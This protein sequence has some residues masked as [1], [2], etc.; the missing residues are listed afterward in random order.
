MRAPRPFLF[1]L[2]R[3]DRRRAGTGQ[4]LCRPAWRRRRLVRRLAV[5]PAAAT[6]AAV[7][8]LVSHRPMA[9]AATAVLLLSLIHI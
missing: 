6:L 8:S 5:L 1:R 9:G 3:R 7:V 2:F 4:Q